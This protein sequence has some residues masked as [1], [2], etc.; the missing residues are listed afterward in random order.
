MNPPDPKKDIET[1]QDCT[2]R[3][4]RETMRPITAQYRHRGG[5]VK[6]FAVRTIAAKILTTKA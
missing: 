2:G 3:L 1:A 5:R 6:G 4:R